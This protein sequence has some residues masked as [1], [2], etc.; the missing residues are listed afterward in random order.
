MINNIDLYLECFLLDT[1]KIKHILSVGKTIENIVDVNKK[2]YDIFL[3]KIS[4]DVLF[5]EKIKEISE[6]VQFDLTR[7]ENIKIFLKKYNKTMLI[8]RFK[9]LIII[10]CIDEFIDLMNKIKW[11]D[12]YYIREIKELS[13]ILWHSFISD[14]EKLSLKLTLLSKT[15][16]QFNYAIELLLLKQ[17]IMN[18]SILK[19]K[20]KVWEFKR[21]VNVK[22]MKMYSKLEQ[23]DDQKLEIEK[24]LDI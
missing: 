11:H 15:E 12:S 1:L 22:K 4:E 2:S 23:I 19:N 16:A 21:W 3:K 5:L 7:V 18:A 10:F 8:D 14:N 24:E 13:I 6:Y 17:K 20:D 9:Y